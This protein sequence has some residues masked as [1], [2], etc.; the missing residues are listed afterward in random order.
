MEPECTNRFTRNWRECFVHHYSTEQ[1]LKC[2]RYESAWLDLFHLP[3]LTCCC[4][5][6]RPCS[7][8]TQI[9]PTHINTPSCIIVNG[10]RLAYV[11]RDLVSV[12]NLK[13]DGSHF[14]LPMPSHTEQ[15]Y[16]GARLAFL[17]CSTC[18]SRTKHLPVSYK[19]AIGSWQHSQVLQR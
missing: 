12:L 19:M 4:W 8:T 16:V 17:A 14:S 13:T 15:I 10:D 9:F 18:L 5:C 2:V 1:R 3:V 6:C 11:E 7:E